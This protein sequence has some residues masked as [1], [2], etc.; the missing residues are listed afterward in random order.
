MRRRLREIFHRHRLAG[1]VIR[2]YFGDGSKWNVKITYGEQEVQDGTG[3]APKLAKAWVGED[4]FLLAYGDILL[5]PPTDYALLVEAFRESGVIALKDGEDLSKGGAV[6]IDKDGLHD[7]PRG[8]GLRSRRPPNA[9]YNAAIYVFPRGFFN[10]RRGCRS[11]R[12]AS[13]S[14]PTR[15]RR[16]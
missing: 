3:K 10:S 11:R 4:G 2:D 12:A 1:Q 14:S 6:V 15:S 9:Y 7:R 16:S 5:K 13:T 8:K